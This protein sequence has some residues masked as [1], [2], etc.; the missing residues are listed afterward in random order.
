MQGVEFIDYY[1]G[2]IGEV[3][4]LHAVYYAENWGF[5]LSFEAQVGRELAEFMARLDPDRDFFLA[6]R[7]QDGLVGAVAMDGTSEEGVRLRWFIVR[8]DQ[9]GS[10]L[11]RRLLERALD[12]VRAAG[13][14]RVFLWTFEGLDAARK[15]YDQAGFTVAE[16]HLVEQWGDS[17]KEQKLVLEL[18]APRSD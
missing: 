3:T 6:A 5:D 9:H 10:G 17:I 7:D 15:L 14:E 18:Q 1:P 4:C 12:F 11:G 16:E 2:V 8:P 13:H